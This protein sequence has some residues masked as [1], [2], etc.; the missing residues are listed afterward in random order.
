MRELVGSVDRSR[1]IGKLL[2]HDDSDSSSAFNYQNLRVVFQLPSQAF[3]ISAQQTAHELRL[4]R[5][6][7]IKENAELR[8]MVVSL[9]S[10]KKKKRKA[11]ATQGALQQRCTTEEGRDEKIRRKLFWFHQREGKYPSN[12]EW[13]QEMRGYH[14][15]GVGKDLYTA[16]K[17]KYANQLVPTRYKPDPAL[18]ELPD[19]FDSHAKRQKQN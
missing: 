19:G 17:K 15:G 9:Q 5:D 13:T 4:E 10:E 1:F 7:A 6:T 11:P 18:S 16:Y 3:E 2:G 14:G 12:R 8:A